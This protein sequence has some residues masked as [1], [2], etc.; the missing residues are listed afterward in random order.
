[1]SCNWRLLP[2]LLTMA[3]SAPERQPSTSIVG[4]WELVSRVERDAAG[5]VIPDSSLGADPVGL[6]VYDATGHLS[7]Q[8]MKRRRTGPPCAVTGKADVNNP[9]QFAGYD[10][11]F[12]RYEVNRAAH[13]ITHHIEG[14]LGPEDVGRTVTREY[15]V[16][17]D[18]LTI[19]YRPGGPRDTHTRTLVLHRVSR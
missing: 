13:T 6:V 16:V 3:A 11:N 15:R 14:A 10:A 19:W 7:V 4:T 9:A 12:G 5:R 2:L 1:M 18:T 17:G 8:I